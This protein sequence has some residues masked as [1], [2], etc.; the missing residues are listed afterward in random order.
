MEI[1]SSNNKKFLIF[2]ENGNPE[3]IPYISR[4]GTVYIL[5]NGNPTLTFRARKYIS[6]SIS[7]SIS[8]KYTLGNGT[9]YPKKT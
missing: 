1:S 9:F 7:I 4:N 8:I 2:S 5:G 3:K 6:I